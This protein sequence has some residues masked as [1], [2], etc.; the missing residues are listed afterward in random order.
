MRAHDHHWSSVLG[1]T[2]RAQQAEH[3]FVLSLSF[4]NVPVRQ[5]VF[6]IVVS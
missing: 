1:G 4:P 3:N 2:V 5:L 6:N